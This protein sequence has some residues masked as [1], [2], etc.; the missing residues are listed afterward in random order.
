MRYQWNQLGRTENIPDLHKNHSGYICP[1]C[2]L[3]IYSEWCYSFSFD[4]LNRSISDRENEKKQIE[5][6]QK[7]AVAF[8]Q[9][10]ECPCCGG[11]LKHD[12]HFFLQVENILGFGPKNFF[13]NN[14]SRFTATPSEGGLGSLFPKLS[15]SS[16]STFFKVNTVNNMFSYLHDQLRTLELNYFHNRITEISSQYGT[17]TSVTINDE[18]VSPIKNDPIKLLDYLQKIID[19]ERNIR[20]LVACLYPLYKASHRVKKEA[21]LVQHYPAMLEA[22]Q[23]RTAITEKIEQLQQ[24]L[25]SHLAETSA[26]QQNRYQLASKNIIVP[27]VSYPQKPTEP[28]KPVYETPGFFNKKKPRL[29]TRRKQSSI[30]MRLQYITTP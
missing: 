27:A 4:T 9:L 11:A 29:K 26:L 13:E 14:I 16:L 5:E 20:S 19:S 30:T 8:S 12:R 10:K 15:E 7:E 3:E 23:K 25:Q 24:T 21:M 28:E 2:G 6:M 22:M 1:S 17:Q 18:S